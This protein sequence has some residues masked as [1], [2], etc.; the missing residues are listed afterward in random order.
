MS[1][2]AIE[3]ARTCARSLRQES[4]TGRRPQYARRVGA[5]A[6]ARTRRVCLLL[7]LGRK[8]LGLRRV[9]ISMDAMR[10]ATTMPI[11][12]RVRGR[13]ATL[14]APQPAACSSRVSPSELFY[15]GSELSNCISRTPSDIVFDRS[16]LV[17]VKDQSEGFKT[18]GSRAGACVRTYAR[19]LGSS[20]GRSRP[21]DAVK[22]FWARGPPSRR[23]PLVARRTRR[24]AVTP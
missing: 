20:A 13:E 7:V 11:L 14:A 8:C 15:R 2:P 1:L 10:A 12:T 18:D 4:A 19:V 21:L 17:E 9:H 6:R 23:C 3:Q 22:K 24:C 16:L 5:H